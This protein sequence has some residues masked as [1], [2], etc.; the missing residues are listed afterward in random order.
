MSKR[1]T[2]GRPPSRREGR[3]SSYATGPVASTKR[4]AMDETGKMF[5]NLAYA[6]YR[7]TD[8]ILG[9]GKTIQ[10]AAESSIGMQRWADEMTDRLKEQ[11]PPDRPIA[12]R[13]G[14]AF[15]C[16]I[17]VSAT[18]PEVLVIAETI[19]AESDPERLAEVRSRIEMHRDKLRELTAEER[20]HIRQACP[21]LVNGQCSVYQIRPLNCRGWNSDDAAKC[22]TFYD[23]PHSEVK[24]TVYGPQQAVASMI[25]TGSQSG[26]RSHGLE[27][28]VVELV[29]AMEIVMDDPTAG[30]RWL[31]GEPVFES[32][33]MAKG[34]RVFAKME[35]EYL[36][37]IP[38]QPF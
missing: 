24:V 19:K 21:L 5:R 29:A 16:H 17:Q 18:I 1:T 27:A 37:V 4:T 7:T 31:A 20:L 28:R 34:D 22:E 11:M 23:D 8:E 13:A 3:V 35:D 6:Q 32:A 2:L 10:K 12:C 25:G 9:E 26:L 15:C 33:E 36:A 30:L 14:C 38:T